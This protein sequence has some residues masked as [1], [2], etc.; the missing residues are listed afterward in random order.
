V[1]VENLK[2]SNNP[3]SKC[4]TFGGFF[5]EIKVCL[6]RKGRKDFIQAACRRMRKLEALLYLEAQKFKNKI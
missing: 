3:Q 6:Q 5:H 4:S 2:N 1:T